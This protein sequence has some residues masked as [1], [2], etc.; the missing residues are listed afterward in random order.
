MERGGGGK[1][2]EDTVGYRMSG[3]MTSGQAEMGPS[4]RHSSVPMTSQAGSHVWSVK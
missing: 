3:M 4:Q 2:E 1:E